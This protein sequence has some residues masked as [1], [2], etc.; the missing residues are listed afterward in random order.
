MLK[1]VIESASANAEH[2]HKLDGR[3]MTIQSI[4]VSPSGM[5]KRVKP[6]AFGAAHPIRHRQSH[7]SVTLESTDTKKPPKEGV[8]DGSKS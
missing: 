5:I 6:A 7:L 4:L 8:R 3:Q 2:N 1:E